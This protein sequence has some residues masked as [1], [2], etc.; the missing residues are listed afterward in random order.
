MSAARAAGT[1]FESAVVAYLAAHGFI[2]AERQPLS[3]SRDRGD[4]GGVAGWTLEAKACRAMDLAGWAAEA[5]VESINAGT[6]WHAVIAKRRG[7]GVAEAYVVVPLAIFVEAIASDLPED[8]PAILR[9]LADGLETGGSPSGS[10]PVHE[11]DRPAA[12]PLPE[13]AA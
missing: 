5:R 8:L 7:R 13:V 4:I 6:R 3:G 12:D 2:H 9:Q 1:A 11:A 10:P